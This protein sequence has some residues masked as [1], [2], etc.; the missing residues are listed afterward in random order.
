[1]AVRGCSD[2]WFLC[3]AGPDLGVQLR[4]WSA[5]SPR[6]DRPVLAHRVLLTD[7]ELD[8]TTGLLSLRQAD[9]LCIYGTATM[10]ELLTECGLLPTLRSY[11]RVDWR[12]VGA[13]AAFELDNRDGSVSG[14]TCEVVEVGNGRLPRYARTTTASAAA[15][16]GY[17]INDRTTGGSAA[18]APSV[19]VDDEMI[20]RALGR[21]GI[22]FIDGTFYE[23]NELAGA[24]RGAA[25]AC[26]MGHIPVNADQLG[27][28]LASVGARVVYTHL[29]NTNQLILPDSRARKSLADRGFAVARDG[30]EFTV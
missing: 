26:S 23:E 10:R 20:V 30:A 11:T 25:P 24:G 18:F 12:D 29:N 27:T 19:A 6:R 22:A 3:N 8:H 28:G 14:L 7:A 4:D 15:V 17:V 21:A 5:M 9:E 13:G 1:M 2:N 16:I